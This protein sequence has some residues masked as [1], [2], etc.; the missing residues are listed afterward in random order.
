[1]AAPIQIPPDK[2]DYYRKR[3]LA[4]INQHYASQNLGRSLYYVD[5]FIAYFG[6]TKE[7]E[8]FRYKILKKMEALGMPAMPDAPKG[9][10]GKPS[11][12]E[13][14][15]FIPTPNGKLAPEFFKPSAQAAAEMASAPSPA[16]AGSEP[17]H[18]APSSIFPL[19]VEP[20]PSA[21]PQPPKAPE[22]V[23]PAAED[24]PI[25][26][27]NDF[28]APSPEGVD[29]PSLSEISAVDSAPAGKNYEEA[30]IT[31]FQLGV[32]FEKAFAQF[33]AAE[34]SASPS[35][36]PVGM[37]PEGS[38]AVAAQAATTSIIPEAPDW[39]NDI[40]SAVGQ[41]GD[42]LGGGG[43]SAADIDIQMEESEGISMESIAAAPD[44]SQ[45]PFVPPSPASGP[46]F[47]T[48]EAA[49][50][51]KN[52][53]ASILDEPLSGPAA[54][55]LD[56]LKTFLAENEL[57]EEEE[58]P[59]P[60]AYTKKPP[61]ADALYSSGMF[62]GGSGEEDT[63]PTERRSPLLRIALPAAAV[64]VVIAAIWYFF[65]RPGPTPAPAENPPAPTQ[66]AAAKPNQPAKPQTT[67]AQP[68]P[69]TATTNPPQATAPAGTA[70]TTP[71][72]AATTPQANKPT[73]QPATTAPTSASTTTQSAPTSNLSDEDFFK[74]VEKKNTS[75]AYQEYIDRFPTGRHSRDARILVTQLQQKEQQ[76]AEM[77]IIQ[78]LKSQK[79]YSLRDMAGSVGE[80]TLQSV[81]RRISGLP[82]QFATQTF[83]RQTV[84]VD[85]ASGLMW[86]FQN[87][88]MNFEKAK[89]WA[90]MIYAGFSDWRLPTV[91]ECITL[92]KAPATFFPAPQMQIWTCDLSLE[93]DQF[94]WAFSLPGGVF[95]V[96]NAKEEQYLCTVRSI[97]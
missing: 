27:M 23:M 90:P 49:A 4:K 24:L 69:T 82:S 97:R 64:L 63:S 61:A 62:P 36:S 20:A 48:P 85:N 11:L 88:T 50:E 28:T 73:Q 39:M 54:A 79:K 37:P 47:P 92:T 5:M 76:N 81:I 31:E 57:P 80:E 21:P 55:N 15:L 33:M 1:M 12:L 94:I 44:F 6:K 75:A 45:V 78:Q 38:P 93:Q 67:T 77:Q 53:L 51:N 58:P 71:Q 42:L 83:S 89:F 87:K 2:V 72:P 52:G 60:T 95:K 91:E 29:A 7:V 43:E 74:E 35:S 8:L 96:V 19:R 3:I 46:T 22:S 70:T 30:E 40:A 66:A 10:G 16:P 59:P 84:V 17:V 68:Q 18:S 86:R 9:P 32:D 14:S 56:P 13:S 25:P 34:A 41:G 26:T 65:L